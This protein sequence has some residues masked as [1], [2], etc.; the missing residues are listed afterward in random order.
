[1]IN[2]DAH[3][4]ASLQHVRAGV[5]AA[6]KGWLTREQVVNTRPVGEVMGALRPRR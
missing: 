4:T 6:R 1:V 5:L 2:P 3:D